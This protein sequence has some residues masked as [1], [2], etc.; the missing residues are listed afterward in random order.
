MSHFVVGVDGGGTRTRAVALGAGGQLVG[1]AVG[2]AALLQTDNAESVALAIRQVAEEAAAD[3]GLTL[4]AAAVHAGVAGAG[5]QA[6]KE[7]LEHALRDAGVGER[8]RVGTD[9]AAAARDALDGG[10]GIVLLAG[11]VSIAWRR[12]PDGRE[13]RAGGW[14][15][16]LGDE[17]SGYALG[18]AGMKA[19]VRARDGRGD[20]TALTDVLLSELSLDGPEALVPW[21]QTAAKARIAAL[22]PRVLELSS[23]DPVAGTIVAD[24]ALDLGAQARVLVRRLGPWADP[25]PTVF[26]AGGLLSP[27]SPL[28]ARVRSVLDMEG[29]PVSEHVV[30]GARG[31]GLLALEM[32]RG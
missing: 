27:D 3:A 20:S 25:G 2:R 22:A 31:A 32:L 9:V 19:V 26:L 23:S 5:R 24:A 11:T 18:I 1:G 10:P 21:S 6:A 28:R 4:P 17:G 8:V 7:A 13:A 30:D 15:A 12:S 16:L 29:L 14:G